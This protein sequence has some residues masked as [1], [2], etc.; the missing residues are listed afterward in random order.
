MR[1][2]GS[3]IVV[4]SMS[5]SDSILKSQTESEMANLVS[6]RYQ[7]IASPMAPRRLKIAQRYSAGSSLPEVLSDA[8]AWW[9]P[10]AKA[11]AIAG[12]ALGCR[13]AHGRGLVHRGLKASNVL[14]DTDR[15]IQIADF[16][17]IRLET[18]DAEPFLVK[19]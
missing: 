16:S 17:P 14:F 2:D 7:F 18:G 11:N 6:L 9:T 8:P 12:I 5:L 19:G 15:Q 1:E 10:T 13:F 4:K 3:L